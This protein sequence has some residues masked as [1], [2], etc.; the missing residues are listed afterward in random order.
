MAHGAFVFAVGHTI[1]GDDLDYFP[2]ST[3][4]GAGL[5][6]GYTQFGVQRAKKFYF[7]VYALGCCDHEGGGMEY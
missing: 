2:V 6:Q 5:P 4:G 3:R 7:S 1:L